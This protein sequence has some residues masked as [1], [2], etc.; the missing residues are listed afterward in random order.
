MYY[1]KPIKQIKFIQDFM[2]MEEKPSAKKVGA[3]D[4]M[5]GRGMEGERDAEEVILDF[6]AY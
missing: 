1:Q 3:R 4:V 2:F 5:M 6:G